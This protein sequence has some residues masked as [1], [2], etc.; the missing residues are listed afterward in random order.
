[1]NE[2]SWR[3]RIHARAQDRCHRLH[4]DWRYNPGNPIHRLRYWLPE[5]AKPWNYA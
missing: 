4:G 5:A 3:E 1:M 2:H